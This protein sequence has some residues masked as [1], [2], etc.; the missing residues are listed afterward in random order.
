ML[1]IISKI[2][3]TKDDKVMNIILLAINIL[4]IS[5][6]LMLGYFNRFSSDDFAYYFR[7]RDMGIWHAFIFA[8]KTWNTRWASILFMNVMLEIFN[9]ESSLLLYYIFILGL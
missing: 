9:P 8:Y 2:N 7:V 6:F 3:L 1:K 4:C 5:L